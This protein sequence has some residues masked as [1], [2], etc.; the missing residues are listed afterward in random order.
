MNQKIYHRIAKWILG[1]ALST[2]LS[3]TALGTQTNEIDLSNNS[4]F[5]LKTVQGSYG[6]GGDGLVGNFSSQPTGTGVFD[7]FLTIEKSGSGGTESGYNT[8]GV[9]YLD[10]QRPAWNTR[11]SLSSLATVTIGSSSYYGFELDANEPGNAKGL[12]SIDNVRIYTSSPDNTS[13]VQSNESN[14]S[15]L[16]TLRWAMNDPLNHGSNYDVSQW[17]NLDANQNQ[18]NGGSGISDMI[19][20][21][22]TSAFATAGAND[23][24][25]FYNLDGVHADA[26]PDLASQAGYEEWRAVVSDGPTPQVPDGGSTLALLGL[27]CGGLALATRFAKGK[28][29]AA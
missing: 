16:G 15:S 2:I 24:V 23:Y 12:I 25:W 6:F 1:A 8:N 21:V 7:P 19:L 10:Q 28:L 22:P 27:A 18:G 4:D 13:L 26:D 17:I 11:L 5:T 9:L 20:Y 14:L 29:Q 3:L